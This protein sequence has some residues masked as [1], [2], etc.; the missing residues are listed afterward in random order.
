[1]LENSGCLLPARPTFGPTFLGILTATLT[2]LVHSQP[3]CAQDSYFGQE[4]YSIYPGWSG[5][6]MQ[7]GLLQ[8][9]FRASID[10]GLLLY[11]E[12]SISVWTEAMAVM[13]EEGRISVKIQRQ[14]VRRFG[15]L[16]LPLETTETEQIY[17]GE[18]LNDNEPHTLSLQQTADQFIVSVLDRSASEFSR[19]LANIGSM[20]VHIGGLP[21][22]VK[23]LFSTS[24]NF[25][26][27]LGDIQYAKNSA[28]ASTLSSVSPLEQQGIVEGCS[29]P[30]ISVS[31]GGGA[32]RCV[33][34]L[35]DSSFCDCSSSLLGG[36]NCSEGRISYKR[37]RAL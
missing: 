19:L 5:P 35:P 2:L 34:L 33:A 11:A 22:D 15:S 13:L 17:A 20:R 23:P 3:L 4:S 18:N 36:A 29:D 31:C 6:D 1:M 25:R 24:G 27:C 21:G 14:E 16:I 10:R 26:G 12:G 28:N 8:L 32:G 30:C 9:T 7:E 37:M